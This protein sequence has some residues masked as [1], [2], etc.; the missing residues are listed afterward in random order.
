MGWKQT[1]W[2][3]NGLRAEQYDA[4]IAYKIDLSTMVYIHTISEDGATYKTYLAKALFPPTIN[5]SDPTAVEAG[6]VFDWEIRF[7]QMIEQP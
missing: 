5:R 1:A 4:L 7:I 3:I 6:A 2:H